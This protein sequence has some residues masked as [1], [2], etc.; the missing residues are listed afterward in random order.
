M[1]R[2]LT[3]FVIVNCIFFTA[4]AQS[5][6]IKSSLHNNTYSI[7]GFAHGFKDSTWLY[8][9]DL[10][11]SG[12]IIDSS[13]IINERFY[14]ISKK[15]L[16][17]KSKQYILRTKSYSDYK[18]F[19][20]ENKPVIFS[21]IKGKFRNSL[22]SG[23]VTQTLSEEFQSLTEPL[24]IVIDSLRRNYGTTDSAMWSKILALEK[25]LKQKSAQFIELNNTSIISA[26]LLEL[27]CKAW[28]LTHTK[29]LYDKLSPE[30]QKSDYG[31][32]I[33]KYIKLNKN[34]EVGKT[35]AD[36]EQKSVDGK[37]IR[38]S[39][40]K[41][42]YILLEF[43]ASWCGPCIRENPNL[44]KVYNK[45]K[46][47]GFEIFG[48]SLDANAILWKKAIDKD[49]LPWPNVSDLKGS[50]NEAALIYGVYEIPS[51]FLIDPGG[52][53]I[54]KNLRGEELE[55]KLKELLGD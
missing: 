11:L 44:V 23:S 20:M 7:T 19:W 42:N 25:E 43:W 47:R 5:K 21:G 18:Y 46:S 34:I 4:N 52:K 14:F 53:I 36:F 17:I 29:Q 50:D 31:A 6:T 2:N 39:S 22:I 51:N 54:A 1:K 55:V 48:V 24:I 49:A 16:T 12:K 13:L 38:L 15:L 41:G 33:Y 9:E 8:L 26:Y 40:L 3:W 30:N 35:F 27:Y 45:Y 32:A 10:S 37:P 28:G